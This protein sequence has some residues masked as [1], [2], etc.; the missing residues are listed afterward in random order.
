M[1]ASDFKVDQYD[2]V[3]FLK[4]ENLE[5]LKHFLSTFIVYYSDLYIS[6]VHNPWYHAIAI[7]S[8]QFLVELL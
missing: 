1:V 3:L 8:N 7:M 2:L 4:A 5:S 6:G